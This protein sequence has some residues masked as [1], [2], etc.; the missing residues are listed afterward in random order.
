MSTLC[1]SCGHLQLDPS[2]TCD[3][4]GGDLPA[5]GATGVQAAAPAEQASAGLT[6]GRPREAPPV[7]LSY[8]RQPPAIL[9]WSER[10]LAVVAAVIGPAAGI[11]LTLGLSWAAANGSMLARL[12]DLHGAASI[13]P[14]SISVMFCWGA[15]VCALR[16]RRQRT[17]ESVA[18][19]ALLLEAV[20]QLA[21]RG[22][23]A[24][25]GA[26]ERPDMATSP[27][28]SR[29]LAVLRQW[30]L[31]P[32]LVEADLVLQ[33]H[34]AQ[35]DEKVRRGYQLTRA[36]VWAM[37]VVGLMGTV[38]GISLAVGGFA[39]L[40]GGGV[41][42]VSEIKVSLVGVTRGLS[43][44]FMITLE[45][46]LGALLLMLPSVSL[47][48]REEGFLVAL[49]HAIA[50]KFLPEIQRVAPAGEEQPALPSSPPIGVADLEAA[51]HN[52]LA[53]AP[54]LEA[55]QEQL[56]R[57]AEVV[58]ERLAHAAEAAGVRVIEALARTNDELAASLL[59][60]T[61]RQ[62][63][64]AAGQVND[65][66]A[67]QAQLRSHVNAVAEQFGAAAALLGERFAELHGREAERLEA[68]VQDL[69]QRTRELGLGL[70]THEEAFHRTVEQWREQGPRV[71]SYFAALLQL[72]Q[73]VE[74]TVAVQRS[75]QAEM[76]ALNAQ[77]TLSQVLADVQQSLASLEPFLRRLT[78]TFHFVTAP[79]VMADAV[80]GNGR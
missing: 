17:L 68:L 63:D 21:N 28:L 58:A 55:W 27:L 45:G 16:W 80:S 9:G 15:A 22:P 56:A 71:D 5:G 65:F 41:D 31:R 72:G 11:L 69:D 51:V 52:V 78:G 26:M 7:S 13:V 64:I 32:G 66:Q 18:G 73:G 33:Q 75:M 12:F 34:H 50:V 10:K 25:A 6:A 74:R 36:F 30:R 20:R 76:T 14:I 29:L 67:V 38:I 57:Q 59:A 44:A 47:Q 46:L 62:Q 2:A 23:A 53:K 39:Q 79:E 60:I 1:P 48:G 43:F 37:P 49:Q 61:E 70:A 77:G 42:N 35:D 8:P 54:L 40:L 4:C 24:L 3:R 19:Q